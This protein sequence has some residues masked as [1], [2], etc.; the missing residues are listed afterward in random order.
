M[1]AVRPPERGTLRPIRSPKQT[2]HPLLSLIDRDVLAAADSI[3]VVAQPLGNLVAGNLP[4][5]VRVEFFQHLP[6]P[7]LT[8]PGER[9]ATAAAAI[10]MNSTPAVRVV[11]L[12]NGHVKVADHHLFV[13]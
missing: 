2:D 3:E 6:E 4:I 13:G 10:L 9:H 1:R 5:L 8:Q 11:A 7:V 12:W